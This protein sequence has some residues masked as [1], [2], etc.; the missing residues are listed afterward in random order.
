MVQ[1]RDPQLI[2]VSDEDAEATTVTLHRET[3]H[4]SVTATRTLRST[5]RAPAEARTFVAEG[6]CPRHDLLASAAAALVASEVVTHAALSG[7]GSIT[8]ALECHV[9]TLALSVTCALDGPPAT[10]E[11]RLA[12]PVAGMIV[13]RICRSSGTLRTAHGLTMWYT[14][15]TGYLPVPTPQAWM[16]SQGNPP[17]SSRPHTIRTADTG[18]RYGI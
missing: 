12:D 9:T 6:T 8:I 11:M 16:T 7:D 15:P 17:V 1:Q 10:P 5:L 4:C 2:A 14:I 3:L 18:P 13:D